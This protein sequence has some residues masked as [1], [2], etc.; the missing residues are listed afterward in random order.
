MT[1]EIDH[2]FICAS[3]GAP[4]A[5]RLVEFG[6]TEGSPNVHQGQGTA[7]RRFF[8][9]NSMLELLWV[10]NPDEAR[11]DI[12]RR[13]HLWDRWEGRNKKC[14][15][16]GVCLRPSSSGD[17][18]PP[19]SAWEYHP[20]YL[21]DDLVIHIGEG[22]S[23]TEPMWFF[24]AYG[25]RPDVVESNRQQPVDHPIGVCELTCIRIASPCSDALS[26]TAESVIQTGSI[27]MS[28]GYEHLLE[29]TFDGNCGGQQ[30][31]FRP[32]LPLVFKW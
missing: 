30:E 16:Y 8:F 25:Q 3:V 2:L 20:P 26:S 29:L 32:E 5:D 1:Y 24:L 15:P 9:H 14:S 10:S 18:K 13:T 17:I 23:L 27:S 6:L 4:E 7:N 22:T 12:A 28:P 19:F 31:D 11:G 21:P